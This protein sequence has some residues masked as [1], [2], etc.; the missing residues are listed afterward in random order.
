MR[1]IKTA[2]KHGIH[3]KLSLPKKIKRIKELFIKSSARMNHYNANHL[4]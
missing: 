2:Q 4:G 3:S 1:W